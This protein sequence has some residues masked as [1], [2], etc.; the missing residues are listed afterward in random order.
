MIVKVITDANV[1]GGDRYTAQVTSL[2]EN[3]LNIFSDQITRV[4]IHLSGKNDSKNGQEDKRCVLEA[5]VVGC[6]PTAVTHDATTLV[7]AI[8]GAVSKLKKL[9]ARSHERLRD[10]DGRASNHAVS[11]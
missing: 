10:H 4:E 5:H 9:L 6:Q 1:A 8:S 11:P 7:L 3:A 2:L